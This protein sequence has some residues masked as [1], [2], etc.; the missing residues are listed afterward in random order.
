M[1]VDGE[2]VV[3]TTNLGQICVFNENEPSNAVWLEEK[4][5]HYQALAA[6]HE[7]GSLAIGTLSGHVLLWPKDKIGR[8]RLFLILRFH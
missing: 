5:E 7:T 6:C 8:Q 1:L 4:I 2:T 3:A